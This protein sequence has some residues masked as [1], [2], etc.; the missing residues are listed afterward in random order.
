[1]TIRLLEKLSHFFL[2]AFFIYYF[3]FSASLVWA[4]EEISEQDSFYNTLESTYT[5]DSTGNTFVQHLFEVK[6]LTPSFFIE[7]YSLMV[8]SNQIGN[9]QVK[10]NN[11]EVSPEITQSDAQ[12]TISIT[13]PEKV[14][15]KDKVHQLSITY[16]NPDLASVKGKILEVHIPSMANPDYYDQHQVHLVTP[17]KFKTPSRISPDNYLLQ[18]NDQTV[19]I[20]YNSLSARG[21]SA[22]FGDEQ[23][24]KL[25]LR[26]HLQNPNNQIGITQI[27][28]P[29]DTLYQKV[30]YQSLEPKPEEI[31]ADKDGNWIA[32]YQI[33]AGQTIQVQAQG[34]VKIGVNQLNQ[35]LNQPI[36][37]NY[38]S[39][40]PYWPV[41]HQLIQEKIKNLENA[42][43]IYDF[44]VKEL[45]YWE[46]A[47]EQ[48]PSRLGAVEA[49]KR[50]N[51][52][53]C[54]EYADVFIT[55]ARA[56]EIPARR[57]TGYAYSQNSRLR[58]L[59]LE[60]DILHAWPEY[61]DS[62]KK[63]WIPVDPTWGSTTQGV[64]YFHQFD[65][66]HIVFAYHGLDS[67]KPYPAGA[68]KQPNKKTKDVEV[69][70]AD[71]FI[72][73]NPNFELDLTPF[74]IGPWSIPTFYKLKITN[75]TGQA[76]HNIQFKF[77]SDSVET[78]L[79]ADRKKLTLLPFS[80]K[81]IALRLYNG[82]NWLLAQ[83]Q[84]PVAV[85]TETNHQLNYE[86]TVKTFGQIRQTINQPRNLLIL[87]GISLAVAIAAGS[88]LV[89]RRK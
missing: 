83:D 7:K 84:L 79:K 28:L 17:A 60:G 75:K 9:I 48:N 24:F 71:N 86:F 21:I 22:I 36:A 77:N 53:I 16:Q 45:N 57:A 31:Y 38:L 41:N 44:T 40:Q 4:Q 73:T 50:P 42:E 78:D 56:K 61:F 80:T 52:A 30:N 64:D 33:P 26:Y 19:T 63:Q 72:T 18:Q 35:N 59:G 37:S 69:E 68:Y 74:K 54:Q 11:Q 29:P 76:W 32:S 15:G 20:S 89:L 87:G 5:V 27:T 70:F 13:F 55:L 82:R 46:G 2:A 1:M 23:V 67:E 49:L 81:T 58:P 43:E 51:Q 12:T 62:Q 8:G 25:N 6:N 10:H 85:E 88:L 34:L 47:F 3:L 14:V 66:N 39:S 65:L